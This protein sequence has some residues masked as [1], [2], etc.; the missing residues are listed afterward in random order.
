M[1]EE[2]SSGSPLISYQMLVSVSAAQSMQVVDS[3]CGK[4]PEAIALSI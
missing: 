2:A 3:W 4:S 1:G